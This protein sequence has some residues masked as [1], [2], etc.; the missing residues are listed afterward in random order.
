MVAAE[1]FLREPTDPSRLNG[2]GMI[3]LNPPFRFDA[4]L[5][6]VLEALL[7]R[8]GNREPGEGVALIRLADE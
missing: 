7:A 6:P 3:L 2:C 8:L 1:L 4:E 5:P